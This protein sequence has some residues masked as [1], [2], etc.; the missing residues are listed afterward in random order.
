M[1]SLNITHTIDAASDPENGIYVVN[2][3]GPGLI[4]PVQKTLTV[5]VGADQSQIN[6][7]IL[8]NIP[9]C[10]WYD[11]PVFAT[12]IPFTITPFSESNSDLRTSPTTGPP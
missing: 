12:A 8:A 9:R 10:D 6:M 1:T 5:P 11:H 2:Y 4:T 7:I 3:A